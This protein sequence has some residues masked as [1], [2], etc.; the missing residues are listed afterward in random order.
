MVKT[1]CN[2]LRMFRWYFFHLIAYVCSLIPAKTR[3]KYDLVIMRGDALGDYVIWHDTL[4][5]YK[6]KYQGKKV[7]LVCADLVRPLAET[8]DFFTE[9]FDFNRNKAFFNLAYFLRM[10]RA[11]RSVT[12]DTVI[13]PVYARH[14]IGDDFICQI[15]S[16]MKIAMKYTGGYER[17]KSF[18][19]FQYHKLVSCSGMISEIKLNEHFTREVIDPDY[20]YGHFPLKIESQKSQIAGDYIVI[21]FSSSSVFKEWEIEKFAEIINYIPNK[22]K[23]V[24]T[25]AGPRDE[26]K[27]SK[28]LSLI[29]EK[30][31]LINM[32]G[33][34]TVFGLVDLISHARFLVGNDSAA[35]HIAAATRVKSV[36]ILL[37]AHFGRFLPYPVDLPFS[38][39]L[40][41]VVYHQMGCFGCNY[42]C[43][44]HEAPPFKCIKEVTVDKVIS[45]VDKLLKN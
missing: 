3:K 6:K 14:M 42:H 29:K 30:N 38:D 21:S 36:C 1:G 12:S 37:G 16:P 34:T 19:D 4:I 31:R 45:V 27:A 24:L 28:I 17:V 9:I 18:Y 20:C 2:N 33:K 41:I 22:Y 25:G 11:M 39:Y 26:V 43:I 23:I 13:Y 35:V 7:L 10:L 32:V 15:K 5:A 40:P 44:Y 8:D